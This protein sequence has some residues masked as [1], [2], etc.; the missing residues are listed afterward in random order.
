VLGVE[1]TFE[2]VCVENKNFPI[3][4]LLS[5]QTKVGNRP[6]GDI[7]RSRKLPFMLVI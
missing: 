4:R 3:E 5:K 6:K 7:A 1:Q 2:R